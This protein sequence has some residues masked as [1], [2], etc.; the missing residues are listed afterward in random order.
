M[1]PFYILRLS[2]IIQVVVS[3]FMIIP[4]G[5]A[6]SAGEMLEFYSFLGTIL[7][8]WIFASVYIL[9][10]RRAPNR[11]LSSRDGFFFVTSSWILAAGFGAIPMWISGTIPSYTDA[12]F[13]IMSGFT[14]TGAS[15]L[16][17]I[18]ALPRSILFWRSLTHWLGGM[19]IVVLVVA[20]IPLLG[21][22][23][24]KLVGAESPGPSVDKFTPK[25]RNNALIL[26][27]I[28]LGLSVIEIILLM[29]G[30]MDLFDASTHTFGTMATGGFSPKA[31]SVG[32][33]NSAYID[34]IITIFMVLAG[35][36]FALYY[37]AMSGKLRDVFRDGEFRAYLGIF[38]IVAILISINLMLKGDGY[39]TPGRAFRYA[40]FQTATII[41]TTGYATCDFELWPNF[42]KVLLFFLMFIG[43]CS[44][45]TGGGIKV[46]RIVTVAK[47]AL[48]NIKYMLHPRGV[49]SLK[50]GN[51]QI[52][53]EVVYTIAGFFGLY[54]FTILFSTIVVST[55]GTDI[56]T[57]LTTALV[58]V[59][60]IGPGFGK[61]GPTENYF[62]FPGYIKWFL[63]LAMMAGRLELFTVFALLTPQFWRK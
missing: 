50:V 41:T 25:I 39:D 40:S 10:T 12:Y 58:T 17:D 46:I 42:S 31:A 38:F 60:N 48:N 62:F 27:L 19:G 57:S 45:S 47:L 1:N 22:G 52:R 34:A 51:T 14:T 59:G 35:C 21:A 26:W 29:L 37:K 6:A 16:T 3:A 43:G 63:S 11:V 15:I 55:C 23:G 20:L 7:L 61:I 8:V 44:G 13:E 18:E 24:T 53:K 2:A 30:G 33:Y 28:Y 36:N 9:V 5:I 32:H 4:A 49:F 56:E 54:I